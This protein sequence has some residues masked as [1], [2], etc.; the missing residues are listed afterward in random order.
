MS[1]RHL[2]RDNI[3]RLRPFS[4]ARSEYTGKAHVLLDAN[5]SPFDSGVNRYPDPY[6]IQLKKVIGQLSGHSSDQLIMGNGSDEIIDLVYRT[7]CTPGIDVVRFPDPSFGMYRAMADINDVIKEAIQL[8]DE[9]DVDVGRFLD[10]Q[11]RYHKLL[12]L[13]SPNN[14]TG[15]TLNRARVLE[16]IKYWKGIVVVDEAYI[17]FSKEESLNKYINDFENLIVLQ[18]F[19]KAKGAAGI[20]LGIGYAHAE[21]I[22]YLNK[23]KPPYNV[24][25][26]TIQKALS[27]L[28]NPDSIQG[29]IDSILEERTKTES[30][31]KEISGIQKVFPSEANFLLVRCDR[32]R[33]LYGHLVAEGIV[34]RDRSQLSGC[35]QCLRMSVGLPE[36]NQKLIEA[37]TKFYQ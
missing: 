3:R 20:R 33:A 24:N 11:S 23:I 1:I 29:Q 9:F 25:A 21:I 13:C 5:E 7:F 17:E 37:V 6:Q 30:A 18:T 28:N 36:E 26:L 27:I 14:P 10:E 2:V 15:N 8:N 34:I 31:L 12:F 35:S 4:S 16:I 32:H 22:A 19:S